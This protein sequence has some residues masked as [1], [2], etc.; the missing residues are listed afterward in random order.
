MKRHNNRNAQ[1]DRSG[2]GKVKGVNKQRQGE[3]QIHTESILSSQDFDLSWF[4]P[5]EG[6]KRIIYSMCVNDLTAVQAPSGTGKSTTV[7][8]QGLLDLKKGVYKQIL[9][10]KTPDESGDDLIGYLSGNEETKLETHFESMR[11]IFH[12]FMS[13]EKLKL[14]E[15]RERIKFAIPN[16]I[17]GKT[18]DDTLIIIDEAQSLSPKTVKLCLE[19][20]GQETK[21]VILGDKRQNYSVKK[22]VD[23][24][25]DFIRKI[26]YEGKGELVSCEDLMGVV[27]LSTEDNMR[28]RLSKRITQIYEDEDF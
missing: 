11:S 13:K 4:K 25:T 27:V 12:A 17:K 3:H 2:K 19:R 5:T 20:A 22:R 14:E 8:H 26:T 18:F 1:Q 28:S 16:F 15:K 7:I 23:G 24:F 21:V 6:Q 10:I 9:F